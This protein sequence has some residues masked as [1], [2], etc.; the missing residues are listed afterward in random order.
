MAR[1]P[2]GWLELWLERER[3]RGKK[4]KKGEFLFFFLSFSLALRR[5]PL[6]VSFYLSLPVDQNQNERLKNSVHSPHS[7]TATQ[8]NSSQL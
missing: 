3:E 2:V 7:P 4:G 1:P 5:F 6:F 8:M